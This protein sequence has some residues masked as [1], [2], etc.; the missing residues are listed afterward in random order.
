MTLRTATKSTGKVIQT[1]QYESFTYYFK[2]R[3]ALIYWTEDNTSSVVAEKKLQTQLTEV[4]QVITLK[5][6]KGTVAFIGKFDIKY[7][8]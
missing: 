7:M 5:G 4:G 3:Y 1:V 8:N 6:H 2:E